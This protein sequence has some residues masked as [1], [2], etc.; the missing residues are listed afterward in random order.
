MAAAVRSLLAAPQNNLSIRR[1][2]MRVFGGAG[3]THDA[4][5]NS[6]DAP[7]SALAHA[8]HGLCP[9][10]VPGDVCAEVLVSLLVDILQ[11]CG[12]LSRLLAVQRLD[13]HDIEGAYQLYRSLL[14]ST[15]G[16]GAA[17]EHAPG[18]TSKGQAPPQ[19][20][21]AEVL[22]V[23]RDFLTAQ[24]AKDCAIMVCMQGLPP[25]GHAAAL[26]GHPVAVHAA[27]GVRV[28]YSVAFVDL[29]LKPVHRMQHYE[30]L[31]SQISRGAAA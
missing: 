26:E 11:S 21:R 18:E 15:E 28:R 14:L 12:A 23:L 9:S 25:D 29:D 1:D 4:R 6:L 13:T 19:P 10:E 16:A 30:Q 20:S 2:G 5:V 22:A 24:A 8:L 31:D 17:G 27:T 7:H 3:D